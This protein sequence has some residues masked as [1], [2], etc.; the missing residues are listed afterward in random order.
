MCRSEAIQMPACFNHIPASPSFSWHYML[1]TQRNLSNK[2]N[3]S[4]HVTLAA[5]PLWVGRIA[6][7]SRAFSRVSVRLCFGKKARWSCVSLLGRALKPAGKWIDCRVFTAS[8]LCVWRRKGE[9]TLSS[10]GWRR[11][12]GSPSLTVLHCWLYILAVVSF[13]CL[14][15]LWI[16]WRRRLISMCQERICKEA[17]SCVWFTTLVSCET[18]LHPLAKSI[19]F[20]QFFPPWFLWFL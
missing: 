16:F 12:F 8:L 18:F 11:C 4:N 13:F 3:G 20:R 2:A 19:C 7:D 17:H 1:I 5:I 15:T 10:C 6:R 9:R 14:F